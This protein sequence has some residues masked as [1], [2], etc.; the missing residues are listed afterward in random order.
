MKRDMIQALSHKLEVAS[1]FKLAA[2]C[3]QLEAG[4]WRL[5]TGG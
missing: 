1:R 2:C 5:T 4:N 3:L